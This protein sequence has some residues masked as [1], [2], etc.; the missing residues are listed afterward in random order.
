MDTTAKGFTRKHI[1]LLFLLVILLLNTRPSYAAGSCYTAYATFVN[2]AWNQYEA[3][4]QETNEHD[5]YVRLGTRQLCRI[6]WLSN[7]AQAEG[8]Y[9]SC[10]LGFT[11]IF[12]GR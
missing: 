7:A 3:C 4:V 6:E 5:W 2:T 8:D 1:A 12:G 10:M 11:K 9:A